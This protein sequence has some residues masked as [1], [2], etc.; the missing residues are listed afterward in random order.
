VRIALLLESKKCFFAIATNI[1][2]RDAVVDV[3]L[4]AGTFAHGYSTHFGRNGAQIGMTQRLAQ[5][6][7]GRAVDPAVSQPISRATPTTTPIRQIMTADN[8]RLIST[9]EA[10]EDER[11]RLKK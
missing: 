10:L 2:L 4:K 9:M 3:F 1:S 11:S 6:A 8:I 7:A 5:G